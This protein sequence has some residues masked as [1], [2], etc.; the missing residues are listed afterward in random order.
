MGRRTRF[1]RVDEAFSRNVRPECVSHGGMRKTACD[2]PRESKVDNCK[3]GTGTNAVFF[4]SFVTIGCCR[5]GF[6]SGWPTRASSLN[7]WKCAFRKAA[8]REHPLGGAMT[9]NRQRRS[10][11][12]RVEDGQSVPPML[13]QPGVGRMRTTSKRTPAQLSRD[14]PGHLSTG[15]PGEG[16]LRDEV[17][18]NG[19]RP[20]R[21]V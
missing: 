3:K 9:C 10:R 12:S 5:A 16:Q 11:C 2:S 20:R 14:S 4:Q 1:W 17:T 19:A 6:V 8:N 21:A 7:S 18:T 13:A 15:N